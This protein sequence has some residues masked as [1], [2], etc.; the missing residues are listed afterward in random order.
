MIAMV[1][2]IPSRDYIESSWRDAMNGIPTRY[3]LTR[4]QIP[5]V[6]D[7]TLAPPGKHVMSVWVTYEPAYPRTGSWADIRRDV[8]NA[9][10]DQMEKYLPDIRD[11]IEQWDVFTPSDIGERVGMTDGNIRHLDLLPR[12]MF[13]NRSL[14]GCAPYRTPAPGLYVCGAGTHPGGEVSGVPCYNAAHAV[15]R[16]KG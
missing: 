16:D 10:L 11:C 2:I 14:T 5:T 9:I 13:A 15:I 3:P 1:R 6:F 4:L 8:G 12:Q 7:P